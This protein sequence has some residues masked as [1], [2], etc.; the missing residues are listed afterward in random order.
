MSIIWGNYES[1]ASS[2][3]DS[4]MRG[5]SE[6]CEYMKCFLQYHSAWRLAR[7]SPMEKMLPYD[8][9]HGL[10]EAGG[11]AEII[12]ETDWLLVLPLRRVTRRQFVP[13]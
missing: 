13:N 10:V 11:S 2:D 7:T 5:F 3:N 4:W 9:R 12:D 6:H 1:E 8:V